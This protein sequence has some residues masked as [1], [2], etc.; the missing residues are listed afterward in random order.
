[1]NQSPAPC[2]SMDVESAGSPAYCMPQMQRYTPRCADAAQGRT[3]HQLAVLE[4]AR[5][6]C[7][8]CCG[9]PWSDRQDSQ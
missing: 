1:M 9:C 5:R 2:G 6:I 7:D 3:S 4:L 8:A